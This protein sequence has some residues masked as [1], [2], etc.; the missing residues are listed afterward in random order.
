M[1][2]NT[3]APMEI[4]IRKVKAGQQDAFVEARARFIHALKEQDGIERDWE[5]KSFFTMPEPDDS[6]VFV[7]MTRYASMDAV[8][9]ISEKLMSSDA[10]QN[11]FATFDMKAFVL[12]NA[13][14]GKP[15][16]LEAFIT[17]PEQVLE[18]AVRSPKEGMEDQFQPL[19]DAFFA[20][21]AAQPG[22][23]MDREFVDL[24]SGANVALIAWDSLVNFQNALT[25]LSNKA[26]MGA[27]FD[28]LNVPAY[29]AVQL[30]SNA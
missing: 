24:Q 6:D 14:D 21:I 17:R 20:Q 23:I 4:A 10:A 12:V 2:Q 18:V 27:F 26:E 9:R 11:F 13:A 30:T 16:Q 22:Y 5:F 7:G 19:R 8:S 25:V 15:F 1:Y 3:P 28:I 29:Q